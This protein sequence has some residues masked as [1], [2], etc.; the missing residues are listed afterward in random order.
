MDFARFSAYLIAFVRKEFLV[1]GQGSNSEIM[2]VIL[3]GALG[4]FLHRY[5]SVFSSAFR[6]ALSGGSGLILCFQ[7]RLLT[8]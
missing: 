6:L 7:T 1:V 3:D 4:F 2:E 5:I 8:G